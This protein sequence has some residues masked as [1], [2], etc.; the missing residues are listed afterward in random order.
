MP[1]IC[2][3]FLLPGAALATAG[4]AMTHAVVIACIL[5]ALREAQHAP[6][7]RLRRLWRFLDLFFWFAVF[8]LLPVIGPC[9]LAL[10]SVLLGR[11]DPDIKGM[12]ATVAASFV[13]SSCYAACL[14]GG[15]FLLVWGARK[16]ECSGVNAAGP[17]MCGVAGGG[18]LLTLALLFCWLLRVFRLA[19][20][21]PVRNS[22]G[23]ILAAA[24]C[25]VAKLLAISVDD[26][27]AA[28]VASSSVVSV[29]V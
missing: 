21:P 17:L 4:A 9:L 11:H 27:G 5:A 6:S 3:A 20:P 19:I 2:W 26:D 8:F 1:A 14:G 13:Y 7:S 24:E 25:Q 10:L 12:L 22:L 15:V 18:V 28:S 16:P 23:P 29:I